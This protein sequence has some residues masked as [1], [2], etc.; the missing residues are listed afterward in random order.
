MWRCHGIP[1]VFFLDDVLGEGY[2]ELTAKIHS[3]KVHS[4]LIRFGFL[5]NLPKS[6]WDPS[7]VIIWL[8]SV[9]DTIQGTI[10]ATA[11]RMPRFLN[12]FIDFQSAIV[13]HAWL[14]PGIWPR[15]LA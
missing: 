12:N 9:I 5:V 2:T 1:I 8:D 4:D 6:Q 3:L 15:L 7:H 11:Q 14:K 10:A 13:N